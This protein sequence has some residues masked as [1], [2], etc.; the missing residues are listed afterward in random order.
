VRTQAFPRDPRAI[1]REALEKTGDIIAFPSPRSRRRYSTR[2][3]RAR[4]T[5]PGLG[6]KTKTA[7]LLK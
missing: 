4:S 1:I 3:D 7:G 6:V 5:H 2:G